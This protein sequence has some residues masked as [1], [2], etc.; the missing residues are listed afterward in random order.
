MNTLKKF[1]VSLPLGTLKRDINSHIN[2]PAEVVANPN[3][4]KGMKT[5]Y[6]CEIRSGSRKQ[7][8]NDNI[9]KG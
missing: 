1:S 5:E 3:A 9:K 7:G 2:A 8:S 4:A 6:Y